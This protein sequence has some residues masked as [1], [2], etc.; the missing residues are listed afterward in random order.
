MEASRGKG[1]TITTYRFNLA[2]QPLLSTVIATQD[3]VKQADNGD[4][5][6]NCVAPLQ[7]Q[8]SYEF[9]QKVD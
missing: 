6:V 2:T 9:G 5:S 8:L 3:L 4:L 1:T 7:L